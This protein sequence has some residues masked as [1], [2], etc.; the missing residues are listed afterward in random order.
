MV[1]A[2]AAFATTAMAGGRA[3]AEPSSGSVA[4]NTYSNS[5]GT[6]S[7]ELYV[8][9][10]YH[11]GTP[12]PMVVALHGC[13]QTADAFRQQTRF[14]DVAAAKG[15]IVVYPEQSKSA[16]QLGCWNWFQPQHLSRGA[17]EPSLIAGITTAVQQRY[18]VD[19]HRTYVA[20]FSAGG[21]MA[22]VMA[23]TYPDLYAA[24]GINSGCEYSAGAACAGSQSADANQAA[25]RAYRAMGQY[26]RAIPFIVFQGDQ[27][28]TVPPV[29]A[30]QLVQSNLVIADLA[31]DAKAN[32]SVPSHPM[33]TSFGRSPGGQFYTT[34]VYSNGHGGE[35]GQYWTVRG[36]GHA[37]SGGD[38]AV[39]FSDPQ[40]PD[41]STA[42]YTFFAGHPAP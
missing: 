17:G 23:V 26:A 29:N 2:C 36:M 12:M 7:Y 14:D 41:A 18:N 35:L 20:G 8:P 10:S 15:F 19:R 5:A 32:G 34:Q 11:P 13:T 16:N 42:M 4:A 6:L 27:D 37:W 28:N 25:Q 9:A 33:K 3:G 1:S 22:E 31:D 24:V 21:A 30:K 40:G 39:Q 38:P